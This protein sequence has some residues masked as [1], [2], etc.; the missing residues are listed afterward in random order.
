MRNLHT[1]IT[2]LL[3]AIPKGESELICK[4]QGV[5]TKILYAAPRRCIITGK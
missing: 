4:L 2:Q 3:E 1:V 5:Q